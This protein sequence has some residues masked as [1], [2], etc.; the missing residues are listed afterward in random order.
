MT[1]QFTGIVYRAKKKEKKGDSHPD[2]LVLVSGEV[3]FTS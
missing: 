3:D 2:K 1:S